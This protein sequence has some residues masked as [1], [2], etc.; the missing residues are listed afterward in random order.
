MFSI[1]PDKLKVQKNSTYLKYS[2]T[3]FPVFDKQLSIRSKNWAAVIEL[4]SVLLRNGTYNKDSH[5]RDM[6]MNGSK[7]TNMLVLRVS[8]PTK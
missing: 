3:Y 8:P 7:H 1:S 2:V 5:V 4:S 6:Q